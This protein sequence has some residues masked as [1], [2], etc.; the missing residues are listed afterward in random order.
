MAK[1]WRVVLAML[2]VLATVMVAGCTSGSD[3]GAT[4]V[5]PTSSIPTKAPPSPA[6]SADTGGGRQIA[7]TDGR[8]YV[9]G[10]RRLTA[11]DLMTGKQIW[12]V[13]IADNEAWGARVVASRDRLLVGVSLRAKAG[14]G[15]PT[16]AVLLIEAATG[17]TTGLVAGEWYLG[18][19]WD[20]PF[21]GDV[22]VLQGATDLRGV[23]STG[24]LRWKRVDHDAARMLGCGPDLLVF[25]SKVDGR[26]TA[27]SP[28]TGVD[29]WR[30]APSTTFSTPIWCDDDIVVAQKGR[31][32]GVLVLDR[33]TG[34]VRSE[35]GSTRLDEGTHHVIDGVLLARE[36]TRA[37]TD[38]DV[39]RGTTLRAYDLRHENAL[40]WER[41][42]RRSCM[43]VGRSGPLDLGA[44][45]GLAPL[46]LGCKGRGQAFDLRTG[47]VTA[48]GPGPLS[49]GYDEPVPADAV[50]LEQDEPFG[51]VDIDEP[52]RTVG[53]YR[54]RDLAE[55]WSLPMRAN[56]P[57]VLT[58]GTTVV[59][60]DRGILTAYPT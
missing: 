12:R 40:L 24:S 55:L 54:R 34:A 25:E 42:E 50:V 15:R 59:S 48:T 3:G 57:L 13:P 9:A 52:G 43:W 41:G 58:D 6:W 37:P 5:T 22:T 21:A 32:D 10:N 7:V 1:L 38:P 56:R 60:L 45:L 47:H 20:D 2:A 11:Y 51:R 18:D 30:G 19:S 28:E 4:S 17:K 44:G 8:A 26:L 16:P 29:R 31:R 35:T 36:P 53:L 49:R 39:D 14:G 46:G 27:I 23:D 33:T